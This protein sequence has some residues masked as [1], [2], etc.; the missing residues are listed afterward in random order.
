M[1]RGIILLLFLSLPLLSQAKEMY[2]QGNSI[3]LLT[4]P[5][6]TAPTMGKIVRGEKLKI[7]NTTTHWANIKTNKHSGWLLKI[8][9]SE[10][11]TIDNLV[12]HEIMT[13]SYMLENFRI[14][15]SS[16]SDENNINK[17]TAIKTTTGRIS[18]SKIERI[19]IKDKTV[20]LFTPSGFK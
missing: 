1:K 3:S 7:L 14:R 20:K 16:I 8:F 6:L 18:L 5:E 15:A 10:N 13:E 19:K 17:N 11:P 12:E 2:F 4:K 9:I